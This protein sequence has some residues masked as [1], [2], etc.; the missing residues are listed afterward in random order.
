MPEAESWQDAQTMKPVNR[1]AKTPQTAKQ[2]HKQ[3][4]ISKT[5]FSRNICTKQQTRCKTP[6][7]GI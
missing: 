7:N 6:A 3:A 2:P 5:A 1:L 4:R